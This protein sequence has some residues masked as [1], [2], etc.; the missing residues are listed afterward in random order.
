MT[1]ASRSDS[2]H[3]D[4]ESL[5]RWVDGV[6]GQLSGVSVEQHVVRCAD[7]RAAVAALVPEQPLQL[8][9]AKVLADVE[10]PRAGLAQRLL[11]R[12]GVNTSDSL[13]IASA[14]ALR[15]GWLL[16]VIGVLF[17]AVLAASFGPFGGIGLFVLG[18]PLV[19]VAGVAAAYGPSVDPSHEAVL[20][21]PYAMVR[22]VLLRTAFVLVTSV[23]LV[24]VAGLLVPASP[25]VAVAWLLP[26]AG[27]VVVVL[28]ASIWVD[29]LYAA[30]V[31]AVGWVI[32]VTLAVR[33]GDP[34]LVFSPACLVGCLA[35]IAVAG[36]IL[37]NRLLAAV[38]SWR[39][40]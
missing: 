33:S 13:V 37:L 2:W 17:F 24:V 15:I 7:C 26:A 14:G 22:L 31:V 25:S 35:V 29:P 11:H 10:V 3:L 8:V 21:T 20:V 32:A 34:L 39:L 5:R 1:G 18:A 6:A 36:L 16:G 38:P 9:W 40:R 28:A 27:F 19:P 12:L 23:P 30:V 4:D